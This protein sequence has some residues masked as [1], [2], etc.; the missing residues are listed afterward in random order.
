LVESSELSID[1]FSQ[2]LEVW[3]PLVEPWK[4]QLKFTKEPINR[5][6]S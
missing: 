1:Y 2:Q 5:V 3:E 6:R 4:F